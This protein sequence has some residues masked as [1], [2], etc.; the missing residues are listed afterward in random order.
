MCATLS[1]SMAASIW[2]GIAQGN[3]GLCLPTFTENLPLPSGFDMTCPEDPPIVSN[4]TDSPW[5]GSHPS[6]TGA[7]LS[8]FK[9][10]AARPTFGADARTC[11]PPS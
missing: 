7:R 6:A 9:S 10:N 3:P 1:C 8:A 11:K 2:S 4:L 5:A